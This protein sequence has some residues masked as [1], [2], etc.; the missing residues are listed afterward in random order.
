MIYLI[1]HPTNFFK[2][3]FISFLIMATPTVSNLHSHW[4]L[5]SK[6]DYMNGLFRSFCFLLIKFRRSVLTSLKYT[7][8]YYSNS[9][10][11][12]HFSFSFDISQACLKR[13][14]QGVNK[15]THFQITQPKNKS[16][17]HIFRYVP[18]LLWLNGIDFC[19][20][21][22]LTCVRGQCLTFFIS[23]I[24]Q[25]PTSKYSLLNWNYIFVHRRLMSCPL[26]LL[27][28]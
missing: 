20:I 23:T 5:C 14:C 27:F 12:C 4:F 22:T 24:Y 16:W 2:L 18:F 6:V 8:I 19:H 3:V 1:V 17:G 13:H 7:C 11:F 26:E 21:V 10:T 25:H 28:L 9:T 15:I